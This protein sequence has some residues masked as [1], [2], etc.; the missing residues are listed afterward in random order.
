MPAEKKTIVVVLGV[1]VGLLFL[2]LSL[3]HTNID[4]IF[5]LLSDHARLW[6]ALPFLVAYAVFFLIKSIRWQLLLK[7]VAT[8][9]FREV[10]PAIMIGYSG[11]VMFPAQLGELAR[12]YVLGKR[13]GIKNSPILATIVLERLFDILSVLL[14]F[15]LV[16]FTSIKEFPFLKI[17]SYV[18]GAL[19]LGVASLLVLAVYKND[20]FM[21]LCS[22]C[23]RMLPR[24]VRSYL[25]FQME[26][27]V[28]GLQILRNPRQLSMVL[29][30]SLVLWFVMAFST[31]IVLAAMEIDVPFQAAMVVLV[32]VILG[33][34]LPTSPGFIGTIQL[35]FVIAL[36]PYGIGSESAVAAS[37]Y[38][39]LL[40]TVPPVAVGILMIGRLGY[41][42]RSMYETNGHASVADQD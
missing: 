27:G 22:I 15:L 40:I 29:A 12:T 2:L 34:S 20:M 38:Y 24:R 28:A 23:S 11:N 39:N 32:F 8:A 41:R 13:L 19:F 37:I 7:P 31:Y 21:A 18:F 26:Q 14:L 25:L 5:H 3:S 36:A 35:S 6:A 17:P 4:E 1:A 33:L 9:S 16:L 30:I 10:F 42:W